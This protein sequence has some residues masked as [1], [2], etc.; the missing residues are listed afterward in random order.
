[1]LLVFTLRIVLTQGILNRYNF[2][3]QTAPDDQLLA[4]L[5]LMSILLLAG[6]NIDFQVCAANRLPACCR[7]QAKSPLGAQA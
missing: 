7:Q 1:M 5:F 2:Q 6:W 4:I 3:S